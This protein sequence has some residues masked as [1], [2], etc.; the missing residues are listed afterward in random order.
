MAQGIICARYLRGG[1]WVSLRIGALSLKGAAL[2]SGALPR[3]NDQVDVA[4]SFGAHRALVRGAPSA[5]CR[6]RSSRRSAARPRSALPS[7]STM[8]RAASSRRCSPPRAPHASRSSLR[9]RAPRA[10]IPVE[11][12]VALNTPR[13]GSVRSEALDVSLEGM[14]MRPQAALAIESAITWSSMLDDRGGPIAGRAKVVREVNELDATQLGL[15]TGFGLQ[16]I[17]MAEADRTRWKAFITPHRA[18]RRQAS[19]HAVRRRHALRSWQR[20]SP[21]WAMR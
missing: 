15:N 12:P 5:R 7:I 20:R 17:E 1:K 11:W 13:S 3:L 21:A 8:P 9:R 19:A 4:L 10:A 18:A 16:I 6:R 2:M 14:F